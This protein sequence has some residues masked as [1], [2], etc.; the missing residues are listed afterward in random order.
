MLTAPCRQVRALPFSGR[1]AAA[2]H[3]SPGSSRATSGRPW[4]RSPSSAQFGSVNL[5]ELRESLRLVQPVG[6]AEPAPE[7][8]AFQVALTGAFGTVGLYSEP[9]AEDRAEAERLLGVVGLQGGQRSSSPDPKQWRAD[10][11]LDCAGTG[12]SRGCSYSTNP[13]QGLTF[14]PRAGPRDDRVALPIRRR[15][16]NR[17]PDHA[18]PG[19]TPTGSLPVIVLDEGKVAAEGTPQD[20][21]TSELLSVVYRCPLDVVRS[22]GRYYSRVVPRAWDGLLAAD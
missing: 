16:P 9:T 3:T 13:R 7:M 8:S 22:N 20:V 17:G 15:S 18:S 4:E 21:L 6:Q 1:M 19:R 11:L 12:A 14:G 5:H 2:K 10:P